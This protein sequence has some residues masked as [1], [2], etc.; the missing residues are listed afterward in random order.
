M[1]LNNT[2]SRPK[3]VA[4]KKPKTQMKPLSKVNS[5]FE[6]KELAKPTSLETNKY[7][8]KPLVGEPSIHT[9]G[10]IV[11]KVGLGGL[12]T[13]TNYGSQSDV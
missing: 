2:P 6:E 4:N 13:E 9:P 11:T 10:G 12:K 8:Q 3:R 7:A 5:K 1:P